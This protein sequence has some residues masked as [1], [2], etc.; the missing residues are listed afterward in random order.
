MGTNRYQYSVLI[1]N[2]RLSADYLSPLN[3]YWLFFVVVA[4]YIKRKKKK[5]KK[6]KIVKKEKEN[7]K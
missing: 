6:E 4:F 3:R 7:S 2:G 1:K 5:N